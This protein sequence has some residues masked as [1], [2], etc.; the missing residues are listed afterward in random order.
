VPIRIATE[1]RGGLTSVRVGAYVVV[2]VVVAV[3]VAVAVAVL[4]VRL[5]YRRAPNLT[6][7]TG[8]EREIDY[9]WR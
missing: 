3:A 6:E 7:R 5:L 1:K 9:W 4:V 8:G 2:V